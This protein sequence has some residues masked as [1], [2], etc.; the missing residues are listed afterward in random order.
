V[1]RAGRLAWL[2]A[3]TDLWIKNITLTTGLVDAY[4]TAMALPLVASHQLDAEKFVTH[5]FRLN[6]T[7]GPQDHRG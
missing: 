3:G 4:S 1:L 2:V 7:S 5:H 6:G